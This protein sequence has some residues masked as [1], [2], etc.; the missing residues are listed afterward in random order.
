MFTR[1]FAE[2]AEGFYSARKT[3]GDLDAR[4]VSHQEAL[5]CFCLEIA[6]LIRN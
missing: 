6:L 2:I 3:A 1:H 5:H 4:Q